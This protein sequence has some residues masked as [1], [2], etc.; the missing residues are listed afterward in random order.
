MQLRYHRNNRTHLLMFWSCFL[1][2]LCM[3]LMCV[4]GNERRR[5]RTGS[6]YGAKMIRFA[7]MNAVR[8][9]PPQKEWVMVL[10]AAPSFS[11]SFSQ[12]S[13]LCSLPS[14]FTLC[15]VSPSIHPHLLLFLPFPPHVEMPDFSPLP[16]Q[17]R[18]RQDSR[19]AGIQPGPPL[20]TNNGMTGSAL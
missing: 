6:D 16:L 20:H 2:Y 12:A 11:C 9:W 15:L 3:S 17:R 13:S 8:K 4:V 18:I 14:P 19:R 5:S 10:I 1:P 7:L